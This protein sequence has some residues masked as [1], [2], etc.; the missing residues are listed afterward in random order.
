MVGGASVADKIL[1][2]MTTR[3]SERALPDKGKQQRPRQ[4]CHS[5]ADGGKAFF[6]SSFLFCIDDNTARC[7]ASCF[8]FVFFQVDL[9]PSDGK[10]GDGPERPGVLAAGTQKEVGSLKGVLEK[11]EERLPGATVLP[12]SAL[13]GI[14]TVDV[15]F[16]VVWC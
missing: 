16:V 2:E 1:P 3:T 15:S 5:R 4:Q 14:N 9:L 12:I 8:F 6:L 13:E 7:C 11:W 10:S